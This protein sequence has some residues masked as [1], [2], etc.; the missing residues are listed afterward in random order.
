MKFFFLSASFCLAA[1]A[2]LSQP[3]VEGPVVE[4][5]HFDADGDGTEELITDL[6]TRDLDRVLVISKDTAEP[7]VVIG[8]LWANLTMLDS[9]TSTKPGRFTIATG[10]D[11]C[12]RNGS[13]LQWHVAFRE[14]RYI[15][16]GVTIVQSDRLSAESV[17]CDVNLLTGQADVSRDPDMPETRITTD[18]RA[19]DLLGLPSDYS[20]KVC[21][22]LI[23]GFWAVR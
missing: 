10:C 5:Y 22:D 3:I 7:P 16:A 13:S 17:L 15:V 1:S 21:D 11:T 2:A 6:T 20:P 8:P 23:A 9:V 12:G 14:G 19:P 18:E 4:E